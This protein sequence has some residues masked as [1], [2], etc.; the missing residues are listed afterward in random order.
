[1]LIQMDDRRSIEINEPEQW[2]YFVIQGSLFNDEVKL[3]SK[4]RTERAAISAAQRAH[5]TMVRVVIDGVA[6]PLAAFQRSRAW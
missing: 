2:A 5:G 6:Y 4:H 1:M 3:I